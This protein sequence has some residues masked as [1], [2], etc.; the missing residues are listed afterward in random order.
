MTNSVTIPIALGGDGSTVTDDANAATGLAN[1][2]H[3]TRFVP[4]LAQTVLMA[5]AAVDAAG[6]ASYLQS[7]INRI[8]LGGV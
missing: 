7:L 2:G 6:K 5:P 1:G 4:A 3:A 8:Y